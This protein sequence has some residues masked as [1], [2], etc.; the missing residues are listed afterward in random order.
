[1]TTFSKEKYAE[2]IYVCGFSN[3]NARAAVEEYRRRFPDR[4]AICTSVSDKLVLSQKESWEDHN[5]DTLPKWK[6]TYCRCYK[7]VLLLASEELP[8]DLAP[9]RQQ[10]R[11][12]C[13]ASVCILLTS[14]IPKICSQ[15]ITLTLALWQQGPLQENFI[16]R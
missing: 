7:A 4:T 10:C 9:P 12:R 11:E 3:G 5:D 8:A 13:M 2:I 16:H 14:E 1:M 6:V 15:T